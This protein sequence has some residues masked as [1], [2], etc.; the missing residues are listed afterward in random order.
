MT[1]APG[2][3]LAARALVHQVL[4]EIPADAL[5]IVG[6]TAHAQT[7]S[8]YH[9]GKSQLR[10]DSYSIIESSRDR[11]GLSEAASAFDFGMWSR[12]VNGKAH[13]LRTYSVWLVAQCKANTPDTRDLREVIYSPDGKIVKRWDRLGIRTTGD[14]SH[15]EHTHHS[16]F[17][18]SENRDKTAIFRRYFT[19]IGLL[20]DD[21]TKDEMLAGL[22]E[23]FGPQFVP[24]ALNDKGKYDSGA[25]RS[26]WWHDVAGAP[27]WQVLSGTYALAQG[28][29]AKLDVP[30]SE[31]VSAVGQVDDQVI[32]SLTDAG[33][34]VDDIAAS[35]RAALGD[36]AAAVG[37]LLAG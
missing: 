34:S 26:A 17:R 9:L 12:T 14:D 29:A 19:E 1:F 10:P 32:A 24:L 7:G 21:M 37:R 6:N 3:I 16:W 30:I 4:P 11:N 31:V 20:E 18:D 35:L 25:G 15:L 8:S 22:K 5:G 23:F 27:A 13:N 36:R 2:S 28:I 33:R